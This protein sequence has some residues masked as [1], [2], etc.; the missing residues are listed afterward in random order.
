MDNITIAYK[1]RTHLIDAFLAQENV[2]ILK[3]KSLM[4]KLS[5]KSKEYA[6]VY[7]HQGS[8]DKDALE[9]I[10]HAKLVIV[11]SYASKHELLNATNIADEKIEVFYPSIND[12]YLKPKES[13]ALLAEEF[14]FDSEKKILLFTAKNFKN[15]GAKEFCD[16]VASLN[17]KHKVVLIAGEAEQIKQLKFQTSRMGL[18][19]EVIYIE[20]YAHPNRL[21]SAADIFVLPTYISGFASNV[22]K[23]MYFKTAVFVSSNSS[24]RE[25]VDVFA[26]M[27]SPTD[28]S[29]PFKVDALLGRKEDLKLIKKQNK[30]ASEVFLLSVQ[31]EKLIG[32]CAKI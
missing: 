26:T 7:F 9:K 29:T 18:K 31:I 3:E 21:F 32:L 23:A 8:L 24:A 19:E 22:L 10:E 15:N 4:E 14:G 6:H 25:V 12:E 13:K 20:D 27:N 1:N 28:G 16:I 17:Y 30:K 5:R 11:S 2:G